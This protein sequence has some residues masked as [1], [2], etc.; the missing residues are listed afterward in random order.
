VDKE[1]NNSITSLFL[2]KW[3]SISLIFGQILVKFF[4]ELPRAIELLPN[5]LVIEVAGVLTIVWVILIPLCVMNV[6]GAYLA[7]AI[8][9]VVHLLLG[10]LTPASGTCDHIYFGPFVVGGHGLLI[11]VLCLIVYKK[12]K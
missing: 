8:W 9:G 5:L 12:L 3:I 4:L 7:G 10:I 11:A 1:K 6:R 2:L